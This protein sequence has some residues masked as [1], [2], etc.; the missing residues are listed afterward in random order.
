MIR[1][2]FAW[3]AETV[4]VSRAKDILASGCFKVARFVGGMIVILAV[5][6]LACGCSFRVAAPP[7]DEVHAAL[8]SSLWGVKIMDAQCAVEAEAMGKRGDM[9]G[10]LWLAQSC[11]DHI[12]RAKD[13]ISPSL[14]ELEKYGPD[15]YR[16][17]GCHIGA[18]T[19]AYSAMRPKL[20]SMGEVSVDVAD[21][22]ARTEWLVSRAGN[23]GQ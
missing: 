2:A 12:Q 10:A 20:E 16:R 14:D 1:K 15:S 11:V 6:L 5:V 9:H 18:V 3:I 22:Q 8:F 23:C 13:E 17:I 19:E 4:T 21:G 7:R